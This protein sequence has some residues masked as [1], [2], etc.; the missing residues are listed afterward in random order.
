MTTQVKDPP[1]APA[2]VVETAATRLR[3]TRK[4]TVTEY[5]RMAEVGILQPQE[6]VELIEGD[7]LVMPPIGPFHA[8]GVDDSNEFFSHYAAGRFRV[9]VQSPVHLGERLEPEPDIALLRRRPGGYR[10]AHPTAADLLLAIEVADTTL[11]YDRNIKS[12]LYGQ[13]GVPETWIIN[14]P[15][16]CLE[17]F[18]NP[19][20]QGYAQH[21]IYRRGDH[22]RPVALPDLEFAVADL[23]PTPPSPETAG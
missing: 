1:A 4:F 17:V 5:Y 8:E 9:R 20:P 19:G 14:L 21:T 16:D 12:R 6:R 3:E 10:N 13:A 23:L 11:A 7:I 15:E 2:T 22:I 18:R